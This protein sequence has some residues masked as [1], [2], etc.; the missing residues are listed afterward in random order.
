MVEQISECNLNVGFHFLRLEVVIAFIWR[1][2]WFEFVFDENI[3][4]EQCSENFSFF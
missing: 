2:L 1:V 3:G 4:G